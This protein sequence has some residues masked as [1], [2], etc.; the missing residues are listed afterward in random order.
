[1]ADDG[2]LPGLF[3]A[4]CRMARNDMT[5]FVREHGR[6]LGSVVGERNQ[7]TRDVELAVW[8]RE[9]IDRRRVEDRDLIFQIRPFGCRHQA[10]DGFFDQ[11]LQAR[12]VVGPAVRSKYAGVLALCSRCLIGLGRDLR[13]RQRDE[14]VVGCAG[15]ARQQNGKQCRQSKRPVRRSPC[16]CRNHPLS[17]TT[18]TTRRALS[19]RAHRPR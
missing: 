7:S 14:A 1:M 9:C 13:H 5:H 19:V 10:I 6:K 2:D 18:E 15:A 8:K 12:V 16:Q 4:D 11:A 17:L 3:L